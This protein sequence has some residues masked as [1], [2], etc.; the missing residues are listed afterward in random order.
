MNSR[1]TWSVAA[2]VALAAAVLL[3]YGTHAGTIVQRLALRIF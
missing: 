3:I 1:L 2:V